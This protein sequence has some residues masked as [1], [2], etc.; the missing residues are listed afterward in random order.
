MRALVC[1]R[2]NE[3]ES[4]TDDRGTENGGYPFHDG[5]AE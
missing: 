3:Y 1:A 5:S 2:N 4:E